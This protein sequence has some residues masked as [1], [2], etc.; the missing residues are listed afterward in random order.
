M[1]KEKCNI[2]RVPRN[3]KMI[4]IAGAHALVERFTWAWPVKND[5]TENELSEQEP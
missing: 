5:S 2:Y 1:W 3:Q 4:R